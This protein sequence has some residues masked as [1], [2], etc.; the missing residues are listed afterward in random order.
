MV[1]IDIS[2]VLP[3]AVNVPRTGETPWAPYFFPFESI[4]GLRSEIRECQI[5][6]HSS[7]K[8]SDICRGWVVA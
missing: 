5:T 7:K 1:G 4:Y 8:K 3:V 6:P 2:L